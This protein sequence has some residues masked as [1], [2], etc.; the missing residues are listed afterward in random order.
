MILYR[1]ERL[2][3]WSIDGTGNFMGALHCMVVSLS[4][5]PSVF[6]KKMLVPIRNS[7]FLSSALLIK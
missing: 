6:W 4:S 3:R 1:Y 5:S 2:L 7:D